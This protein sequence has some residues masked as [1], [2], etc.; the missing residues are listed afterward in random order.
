MARAL[1]H[2]HN[3]PLRPLLPRRKLAFWCPQNAVMESKAMTLSGILKH[4]GSSV[5]HVAPA[6]T[7]A[8][9][10][11]LLSHHRIG[12]VLVCDDAKRLLGVVSERD[13]VRCLALH[14]GAVLQMT[15]SQIMTRNPQTAPPATSVPEAMAMMTEGRF[16]HLPVIE[17]GE[18]IGIVSIGDVVKTR[19]DELEA[20]R[21]QLEA[22]IAG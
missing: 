10:A 16:R 15:A 8:D 18:L 20:H 5:A 21:D 19:L 3:G 12:A 22:Y 6:V 14:G 17:N 11:A 4:K 1:L 9:V 2:L 13:I 7:I